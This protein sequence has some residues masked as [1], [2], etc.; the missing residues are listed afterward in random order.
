MTPRIALPIGS[1]AGSE[2]FQHTGKCAQIAQ[3]R[4]SDAVAHAVAVSDLV[5]H[6]RR[7][8]TRATAVIGLVFL[9]ANYVSPVAALASQRHAPDPLP[10]LPM[11]ALVFPAMQAPAPAKADRRPTKRS[12]AAREAARRA[13]A[14]AAAATR[15][16]AA[17][18][19]AAA[20]AAA[21]AP[22]PVTAPVSQPAAA[23]VVAPAATPAAQIVENQ[24]DM[25]ARPPK[26][27]PNAGAPE[28]E[29]TIG[30]TPVDSTDPGVRAQAQTVPE[31]EPAAPIASA[32]N[33]ADDVA[34]PAAAE[35]PAAE[36]QATPDPLPVHSAPAAAQPPTTVTSPVSAG[37][38]P[39]ARPI[40]SAGTT[41]VATAP[42]LP[43]VAAPAPL[44]A[45]R[46]TPQTLRAAALQPV[47]PPPVSNALLADSSATLAAATATLSDV[48]VSVPAPVVDLS[49]STLEADA[50]LAA[51]T[52]IGSANAAVTEA[53]GQG[54]P[55]V[56]GA[57]TGPQATLPTRTGAPAAPDTSDATG[58]PTF[59]SADPSTEIAAPAL[60]DD[61]APADVDETANA[62]GPP[63]PGEWTIVLTDGI[64][65]LASITTSGE[66]L[67]VTVDGNAMSRP[68]AGLERV[69][70]IGGDR[71][72]SLVVVAA[73]VPIFYD[74]RGGFDLLTI[75][76]VHGSVRATAIDGTSGTILVD[77]LPVTYAGLEPIILGGTATDVVIDGSA[78]DD[79]IVVSQSGSTITVATSTG[80]IESHIFAVPTGS[81]LIRG[82][83]GTDSVTFTT[84]LNLGGA[85]LTVE[86]ETITVAT[87]IS[88]G[89]VTLTAA[90]TRTGGTG[91]LAERERHRRRAR[92]PRPARSRS[93]PP[94][95]TPGRSAARR[96]RRTAAT[97]SARARS[98][99]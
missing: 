18:R 60:A 67:V 30:A 89:A 54:E 56:L 33:A 38:P 51:A 40:A 3:G 6:R 86:A 44:A 24:Y 93:R 17:A 69:T 57:P 25:T 98:P 20:A 43:V 73:P 14:R 81:L 32:S 85:T 34:A 12:H 76:G 53:D 42:G 58:E 15:R 5:F 29:T 72:D 50:L 27:D 65:H 39:P 61:V 71:D 11:P 35:A 92:S 7:G 64:D 2:W 79:A 28:Y 97:P 80:T 82:N 55:A 78:S 8:W 45:V 10:S 1:K 23:P 49:L 13:A 95:P 41:T 31:P 70:V 37:E 62:R 46:V 48:A 36:P 99:Q 96:S 68:L 26:K 84:A 74:G 88:A 75:E 16:A 87:T 4:R 47:A 94:R 83:G 19:T 52:T 63:L 9:L 90:A 91:A 77:G 66:D 59:S 22:E 21:A